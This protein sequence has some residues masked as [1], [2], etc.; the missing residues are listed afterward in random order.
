LTA[1]AKIVVLRAG[2]YLCIPWRMIDL[3]SMGS[4]IVSDSE[5]YPNW[6]V[7]LESETHYAS[8]GIDRP[9]DT[10][11]ASSEEYAKVADTIM[12]LVN[13]EHEHNR[14]RQ[15]SA[16]YFDSHAAPKKIGDYILSQLR[17][18]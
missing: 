5:F 16:A 4:C 10:A 3:L 14:L 18:L 6:P 1:G 8:F 15:N 13:D 7:P 12:G 9:A 2:K 11:P 17:L